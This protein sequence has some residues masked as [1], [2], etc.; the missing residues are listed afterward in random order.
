MLSE[1]FDRL[2]DEQKAI[3]RGFKGPTM[4]VA[5]PGTGKT[6]TI[7][8]LIGRLLAEGT[9]LR[10]ILALTFSEKAAR[11]LRGRVMEYHPHSYDECWI[12]TFHSFC[13]RLLRE[14]Y[15]LVGIRPDFRLLTGFKE[16]LLMAGICGRLT[17][18]TFPVFG[19][20][21]TKRGFQLEVLTFISLLKSNLVTPDQLQ[22]ALAAHP[23]SPM[24]RQRIDELLHLYRRYEEER[25]RTGYL[26]FRDL[27]SFSIQALRDPDTAARYRDRFRIVLVDEFQDT[28]P[29]QYLLLRLLKRPDEGRPPRI[30]VIGDPL[31][32]IYRFRG[33]DPGM[34][35]SRSAF[36]REFKARLFPL[37]G[38]YRSA[39]CILGLAGNLH[40]SREFAP[41]NTPS[42]GTPGGLVARSNRQG[43]VELLEAR[44]E[45]DEARMIARRIASLLTYG[46]HRCFTPGEIA[47]LVRNNYQI[48]LLS[49]ALRAMHI[50]FDIAGD[51]KFFRSEE[52][53]ALASLFQATAGPADAREQPLRRAFA[54]PV[55]GLDPIW[56]QQYLAVLPPAASLEAALDAWLARPPDEPL[57]EGFPP[58]PPETAARLAA[59]RET[60][61]LLRD[62]I[63]LPL[64]TLFARLLL[65]VPHLLADPASPGARHVM[66]FRNMIDDFCDVREKQDGHPPVAADLMPSFDE[67]LTYYASTLE[68]EDEPAADATP[69]IPGVRLMTVHQSKG[70][71]FPVVFVTGL[72]EDQFPVRLRE[73]L[74]I[75]STGLAA[76]QKAIDASKREIRF[77]NPYPA[78]HADHLEE[79]RR[80]LYVALTR[81]EEGL[82]LTLPRRI[83]TDPALPAP[84]LAELGLHPVRDWHEQRILTIGELRT[85]LARLTSEERLPLEPGLQNLSDAVRETAGTDDGDGDFLKPRRFGIAPPCP[86][87][88][89]AGFRFSAQALR[90][91]I[92]CPRRFFFRHVLRLRDERVERQPSLVFGNA[93]HACLQALHDPEGAFSSGRSPGFEELEAL[94]AAHGVP[95]LTQLPVLQRKQYDGQALEI[96]NRYREAVYVNG[97]IPA[98]G[99]IGVEAGF[100]FEFR[101]YPCKGRIDRWLADADGTVWIIDYKTGSAKS[102]ASMLRE[103]FPESGPPSEIQLPFYLLAA[104]QLGHERVCAG[105]VYPKDDLYKKK[106]NG[107]QPGFLK[108]AMLGLGAG[109]DW[110]VQ[111]TPY[112]FAAFGDTLEQLMARIV[113]ERVFDCR[114]SPAASAMSCINRSPKKHCEFQPFCQERLDQL[115]LATPDTSQEDADDAD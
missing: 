41:K 64:V 37:G 26:D 73:N 112:Q 11:E 14:Q 111:V 57:P 30:A 62:G 12:S 74:L 8:V 97:Q 79:E 55:F 88:L 50:P 108:S 38:N 60:L 33:A 15:H 1:N 27:I 49:E 2:N 16:A 66:R 4:I 29:A 93:V 70:L 99:T 92:D 96:L 109:P 101:G 43:F 3:I 7:A 59:F 90:D 114:P 81:A 95:L 84:F 23:P 61:R 56:V 18:E 44:D 65:A 42:G 5:G 46:T 72:C 69:A 80:L 107:F 77:F 110:A 35:S 39:A 21:L 24:V 63:E 113:S 40:W 9:K 54:S 22:Q 76:V 87:E 105:T 36:R 6:R 48:D 102:A 45:L 83:G 58:P 91:F 51:M 104:R 67:W 34:M 89:P 78:D 68:Q 20:V 82:I 10:E 17:P 106:Y 75:G 19:R 103:A 94:W 25:I 71:E 115:R 86:A 85:R 53:T 32:S 28:D 52:V 13:A 31:Q 47:I 100:R 98:A